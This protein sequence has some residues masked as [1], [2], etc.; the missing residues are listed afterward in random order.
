MSSGTVKRQHRIYAPYP[1]HDVLSTGC[2]HSV[3][4]IG[5]RVTSLREPITVPLVHL[6]LGPS[7]I[8]LQL[9]QLIVLIDN[10]LP[11][12]LKWKEM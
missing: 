12:E 11:Q 9:W 1:M 6:L 2:L 10:Q 7:A 5:S 3:S 4:L 8:Q